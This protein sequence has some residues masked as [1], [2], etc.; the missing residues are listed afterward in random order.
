MA[1]ITRTSKGEDSYYF[2]AYKLTSNEDSSSAID[3]SS[4]NVSGLEKILTPE[5]I[6]KAAE[7]DTPVT[8]PNLSGRFEFLQILHLIEKLTN[9]ILDLQTKFSNGHNKL[10][11]LISE[12]CELKLENYQLKQNVNKYSPRGVSLNTLK[13]VISIDC[14]PNKIESIQLLDNAGIVNGK[15][16]SSNQQAM[17]MKKKRP[18]RKQRAKLQNSLM[19][20]DNGVAKNCETRS[21]CLNSTDNVTECGKSKSANSVLGSGRDGNDRGENETVRN[22]RSSVSN[23]H[24]T[25]GSETKSKET[26]NSTVGDSKKNICSSLNKDED[27]I[28]YAAATKGKARTA[29]KRSE[30]IIGDSM[31]KNI[32]GGN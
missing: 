22:G 2:N 5:D 23:A 6:Q 26:I 20:V 30:V 12:N 14:D 7:N 3:L 17:Q 4:N 8:T 1:Y 32:N 31:I 13:K 9:D 18:N 16:K 25:S 24:V 29:S 27:L 21:K 19:S 11:K 10:E 28:S 15:E